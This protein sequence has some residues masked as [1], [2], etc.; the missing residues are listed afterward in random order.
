[1]G[2]VYNWFRILHLFFVIAW[3]VGIFYLPRIMVHYQEGK[4]E[5]EGVTRLVKMAR[6]LLNFSTLMALFATGCGA[7]MWLYFGMTG[8]WLYVKLV[9]VA[10]FLLHHHL[11]SRFVLQMEK[12]TLKRSSLFFRWF[13]EYPTLLLLAIIILAILKPF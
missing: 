13:N 10:V 8:K 9:I 1:M 11:C 2:T 6:K 4:T 5:G 12:D 7:T 3:M